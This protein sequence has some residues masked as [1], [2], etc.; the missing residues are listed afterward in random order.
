MKAILSTFLVILG[1]TLIYLNLSNEDQ[2][3]SLSSITP[4]KALL[5]QTMQNDFLKDL[6]EKWSSIRDI[7][8][9]QPVAL[10]PNENI[11]FKIPTYPKGNYRLEYTII[12]EDP[13]DQTP[14]LLV[15]YELYELELPGNK[16]WEKIGRYNR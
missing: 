8:S 9:N 11:E 12:S 1:F 6:P 10:R 14:K 2:S 3:T 16:V 7:K 15:L 5:L 4:N 13:T